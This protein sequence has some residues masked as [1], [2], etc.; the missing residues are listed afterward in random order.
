MIK[1]K[2]IKKINGKKK[3]E[4]KI[5]PDIDYNDSMSKSIRNDK[6]KEEEELIDKQNYDKARDCVNTFNNS[7]RED[8]KTNKICMKK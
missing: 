7:L 4:R 8:K 6:H 2:Y 1:V 3:V 5:V